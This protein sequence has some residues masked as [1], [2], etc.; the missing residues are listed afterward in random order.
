MTDKIPAFVRVSGPPN[1]SFLVGYPGISA[2]LVSRFA[3]CFAASWYLSIWGRLLVIFPSACW[4]TCIRS[5]L[6]VGCRSPSRDAKPRD[7]HD[8]R[9]QR[10]ILTMFASAADRRKS[11]DPTI[12]GLHGARRC[13]ISA[14]MSSAK[15]NDTSCRQKLSEETSGHTK[16][17]YDRC[18]RQRIAAFPMRVRKG[19]RKC[20][21]DGPAIRTLH[22]IWTGRR[23]DE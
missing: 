1:S 22:P 19:S 13:F 18:C 2:T 4:S 16:K 8:D 23:R 20:D 15:R 5:V 6:R 21:C 17:R 9:F 14:H 10:E 12:A 11:R 3:Y 7:L